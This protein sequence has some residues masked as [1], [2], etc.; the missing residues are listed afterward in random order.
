MHYKHVT[1]G[2][3]K[4]G[5]GQVNDQSKYF[6]LGCVWVPGSCDLQVWAQAEV[7]VC[8]MKRQGCE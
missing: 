1:T 2:E 3:K 4:M 5:L 8:T 6:I 7:S